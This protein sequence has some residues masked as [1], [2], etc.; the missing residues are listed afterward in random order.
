MLR[1]RSP[2]TFRIIMVVDHRFGLARHVLNTASMATPQVANGGDCDGASFILSKNA[3]STGRPTCPPP[4]FS[5][6]SL[7]DQKILRKRRWGH[8][9]IRARLALVRWLW[10]TMIHYDTLVL[11]EQIVSPF[12]SLS[13]S[14]GTL[15]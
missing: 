3:A 11:Y 5:A 9:E 1:P 8:L 2:I 13:L 14:R 12:L 4:P 10:Y 7:F 15:V 6:P